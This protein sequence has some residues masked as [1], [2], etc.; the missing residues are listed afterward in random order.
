MKTVEYLSY[1]P[2]THALAFQ[3]INS[4]AWNSNYAQARDNEGNVLYH[5]SSL[6]KL[7]EKLLVNKSIIIDDW[8]RVV[9]KRSA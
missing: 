3:G 8:Q 4:I 6:D 1:V 7:T 9:I 2:A 5:C